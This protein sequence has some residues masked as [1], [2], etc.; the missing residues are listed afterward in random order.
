MRDELDKIV[1]RRTLSTLSDSDM[2]D[3]LHYRK[4]SEMIF[5]LHVFHEDL[6]PMIEG[7]VNE[8]QF[9]R[10]FVGTTLLSA[11]STAS[12]LAFD[13]SINGSDRVYLTTWCCMVGAS[14]S[15]K[16]FSFDKL[17]QPLIQ[18]QKKLDIKWK[19]KTE[20]LS[21]TDRC[22]QKIESVIFNDS[23]LNTL[24]RSFLPD[25]PKGLCKVCYELTEWI[26]GM[27][28]GKPSNDGN[29]EQ[30]WLKF[31]NCSRTDIT[32]AG[33]Q[34]IVIE[35][36]FLNVIGGIQFQLIEDFYKQRREFSG[37]SH[38]ILFCVDERRIGIDPNPKYIMPK[39]FTLKYNKLIHT[40]YYGYPV[41]DWRQEPIHLV[42]NDEAKDLYQNYFTLKRKEANSI[43]DNNLKDIKNG[44]LGKMRENALK[45]AALLHISDIILNDIGPDG[46]DKHVPLSNES[47]ITSNT[48][49]RALELV[50]YF[51]KSAEY[52]YKEAK[53]KQVPKEVINIKAAFLYSIKECG[54]INYSEM[55]RILYP[56][57]SAANQRQK[58]RRDFEKACKKYGKY[59]G[60]EL[61]YSM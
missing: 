18:I 29:D 42:L 49:S 47:Y 44:I 56:K 46:E 20:N 16:T 51:T 4:S 60:I 7:Y 8:Y 3:E 40:L 12:G 24:L 34:K 37:F 39:E 26:N 28:N 35:R 11:F 21:E 30:I 61:N 36:P 33:K 5:P 6:K 13:V 32:R 59:F 23:H 43:F 17:Y 45:F 50:D 19:E 27:N 57:E 53:S 1:K 9:D 31:Y 2:E 48:L 38:R 22:N 25:N 52:C 55:G 10:S 54:K 14:S 58:A 15:G 41:M